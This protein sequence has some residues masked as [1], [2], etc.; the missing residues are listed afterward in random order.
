MTKFSKPFLFSVIVPTLLVAIFF[1]FI[2][3]PVYRSTTTILV[4]NPNK[5]SGGISSMLSGGTGDSMTGAF[6]TKEF[7]TSWQE[8]KAID[9]SD[10]N[11]QTLW[12]KGD[13]ITSYIK[14]LDSDVALYNYY[15]RN[16]VPSIDKKSGIITVESYAHSAKD[17]RTLNAI[18][19]LHTEEQINKLNLQKQMD[20]T[21]LAQKQLELARKAVEEDNAA[22]AAFRK[23][24]GFYKPDIDYQATMVAQSSIDSNLSAAK[25]DYNG[26]NG[27][28]PNNPAVG[29]MKDK[30]TSYR[31]DTAALTARSNAINAVAKQYDVLES[32]RQMDLAM[33]EKAGQLVQ[34]AAVKSGGDHY[35]LNVISEPSEPNDA[36]FPRALLNT[37]LAFCFFI[38]VY[39]FI[40][41]PRLR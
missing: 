39:K 37:F 2:A 29:G 18:L 25:A 12:G 3:T 38:V 11:I 32:K 16:V 27:S 33:L 28:T 1:C 21:R 41:A 19:L 36:E 35:Y 24:T 8:F 14:F 20:S 13:P 22:I 7:I 15:K 30:I 5:E 4:S 17:A 23:R 10:N 6:I 31:K 26:V 9:G 34:D 40:V